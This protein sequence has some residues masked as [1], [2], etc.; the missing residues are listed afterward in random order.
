MG[1]SA[2]KTCAIVK[3][4]PYG[5][6]F[7]H[8]LFACPRCLH[9]GRWCTGEVLRLCH[10][11]NYGGPHGLQ[12]HLGLRGLCWGTGGGV[13]PWCCCWLGSCSALRGRRSVGS[14]WAGP[15]AVRS[16]RSPFTLVMRI[17]RMQA[18]LKAACIKPQMG[19]P[20]GCALA[21]ALGLAGSLIS[22]FRQ[23]LLIR[24]LPWWTAAFTKVRMQAL[25]GA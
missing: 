4:D 23:P 8:L 17:R 20:I 11:L 12:T 24:Y 21:R 16:L 22:A 9:R 14:E 15:M 25:H 18:L 6:A 3:R 7:S 1:R 10:I 19:V 2:C 13:V 5:F